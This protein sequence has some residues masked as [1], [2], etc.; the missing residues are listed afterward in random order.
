MENGDE[1]S[2]ETPTPIA[3][4]HNN[5]QPEEQYYL[6]KAAHSSSAGS[7]KRSGSLLSKLS[8]LRMSQTLEELPPPSRNL[9]VT[10]SAS[11][12]CDNENNGLG[13]GGS[14]AVGA[15]GGG[16]GGSGRA[17]ATAM[18]QHQRRMRRRKGSLRKT[19]LLGTRLDARERRNSA[20][21]ARDQNGYADIENDRGTSSSP[22]NSGG[23][24]TSPNDEEETP[25]GSMERN[26]NG[27]NV[28]SSSSSSSYSAYW[29]RSSRMDRNA[30]ADLDK[31]GSHV[32][33]TTDEEDNVSPFNH[34]NRNVGSTDSNT[35][36]N[37]KDETTAQA[38]PCSASS[39]SSGIPRLIG[40]TTT[41]P[42]SSSDSYF[43]SHRQ[44]VTAATNA[45][46]NATIHQQPQQRPQFHRARSPLVTHS[47]IEMSTNHHVDVGWDYA[48]TEWW[49]WIILIVTW[50]VFVV[51]IGSSF[52]V[53][54]WAWD[55]GETPYAPPE[56]E[57][58]PTLPI[59]G[60]YPALMVMT[61]VMA[62]VWVIVAWVGMKYF[63]HANI[64]AD[65]G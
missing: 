18:Q 59:V 19:A 21:S 22:L 51:G 58:D 38:R 17:M 30:A 33:N 9:E 41:T 16:G 15:G 39:S 47:S 24:V 50:L 11:P 60:Y 27:N 61:A 31:P 10:R 53:W 46:E 28:L 29:P 26:S 55:V 62:W 12:N 44:A 7:H 20:G 49:G 8:F 6:T 36:H 43:L 54:S 57:D 65:D 1:F 14:R 42:S 3:L 32:G 13:V 23:I 4:A 63:K 56:L 45:T 37:I 25:R 52:G 35:N 48:E 34:S 2:L 40:A 64:S 5:E